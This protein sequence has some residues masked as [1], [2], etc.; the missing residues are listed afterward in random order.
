M[1][2]PT[3]EDLNRIGKEI[4]GRALEYDRDEVKLAIEIA[5]K[6][7]EI[8]RLRRIETSAKELIQSIGDD[9]DVSTAALVDLKYALDGDPI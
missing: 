2:E 9:G 1:S 4:L 3:R 7:I 5:C 8:Q 6:Q